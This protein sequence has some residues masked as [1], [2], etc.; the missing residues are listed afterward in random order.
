MTRIAKGSMILLLSVP[1]LLGAAAS[2]KRA[3]SKDPAVQQEAAKARSSVPIMP[4][5]T[6]HPPALTATSPGS[7]QGVPIVSSPMSN[8]TITWSSINGGGTTNASSTNYSMGNSVGQSAAGAAASTNYSVGIGFWYGAA[9]GCSCPSQGDVNPDLVVDV[10]DV[11]QAI[12]IAFSGGVD[13]TDPGCPT[14]RCD[15]NNDGAADVFDVIYL[16]ATAFSGGPNPID[17]CL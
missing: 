1:L 4:T 6:T 2:E 3:S 15:V 14:S 5:S 11:I 13:I 17:P 9:G 7:S 16:I 8:Y 10:F 12:A